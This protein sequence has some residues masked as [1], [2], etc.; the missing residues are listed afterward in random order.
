MLHYDLHNLY[1]SDTSITRMMTSRRM[2]WVGHATRVGEKK[3]T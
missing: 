3:N 1:L 2:R